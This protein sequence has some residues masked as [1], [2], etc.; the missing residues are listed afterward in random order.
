VLRSVAAIVRAAIVL[1]AGC[2]RGAAPAA[3]ASTGSAMA[4][5]GS[6]MA[7]P[8]TASVTASDWS[9]D[10]L[11]FAAS[12]PVPEAS[13]AAWLTVDN[14]LVLV[15]VGDSGNHG[16]Y[17]LVDPETGDT[18]EQ[19]KL[20]LGD[21]SDDLEGASVR[22]GLLYGLTSG[23]WMTTWKRGDHAF[24]LVDAPYPI[25]K[26]DRALP[27]QHAFHEVPVAGDGI[28][29]DA[30]AF[31]CG[32]DFEGLALLDPPPSHGG[33]AACV[34]FAAAK[35]DGTLDCLVEQGGKLQVDTTR[36]LAIARSGML[37][38]VTFGD[39]GTLWAGTNVFDLDAIYRIDNWQ[40][41]AH[42]KVVKLG[43]FGVG[44]SE[45]IAVRGDTVYRMSDTNDAPSLM[46]KL[47]CRGPTR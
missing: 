22:G 13:A 35:A 18:I 30:R 4:S 9:C 14:K 47:R 10:R 36:R 34:G 1:A 6:A 17:A 27:P 33:S 21:T 7:E 2:G 42:A 43:A 15:V 24:E 8:T 41:V 23:G 28:A 32:H 31:N 20:P 29:C 11:P 45:V 38:D 46:V 44:N 26:V 3:T 25:G 40:D 12:T 37:A 19:G 5:T 16:A 39:D